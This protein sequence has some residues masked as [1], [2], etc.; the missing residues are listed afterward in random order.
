MT[1]AEGAGL[2]V[3]NARTSKLCRIESDF[4]KAT[5]FSIIMEES[6]YP[7]NDTI[8]GLALIDRCKYLF[9]FCKKRKLFISELIII[10]HITYYGF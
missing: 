7:F 3:Y 9:V 2:V 4:M 10:H 8:H 5:N 6:S 1:D